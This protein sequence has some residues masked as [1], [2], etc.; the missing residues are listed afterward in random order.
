MKRVLLRAPIFTQSGYGVHARQI[1]RWL[2]KKPNIDLTVQPLPWG[3]T[4]WF[5]K[6]PDAA[7][8]SLRDKFDLAPS[9]YDVSIQLQLPSEWDTSLSKTTIGVT[10]GIETTLAS[11]QWAESC[12][13]LQHIIVPSNHAKSSLVKAGA[14]SNNIKIVPESFSDELFDN[15]KCPVEFEEDFGILIVSQL[16]G[17]TSEVDRKNIFNTIKAI[18]EAFINNN[19]CTI[20]LKT[21]SS[22]NT[23]ID[24]TIVRNVFEKF[25]SENCKSGPKIRIVHGN[26][27][28]AEMGS[29]YRHPKIKC[30]VS[31]TRGEG[32]GLPCLEA[33]ACG[34]PVIA[35]D[36]S[37]HTEYLNL[38][39]W[40]KIP[41]QLINIPQNKVDNFIFVN[42]AQWAEPDINAFKQK[43]LKLYANYAMPKDW[44]L[45]LQKQIRQKYNEIYVESLWDNTL[46]SLL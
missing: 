15:V 32:F 17:F 14:N 36:W 26:L 29:L 41:H 24:A 35:T 38:G 46:E 31:L 9:N 39:K 45:E 21:N 37:A 8:D 12:N 42:N 27:S 28:N 19:N 13:K 44:A 18:R 25:V 22:R 3:A 23:A 2:L 16:T 7:I 33:A 11:T 34:L 10:A 30:F 1:A 40:T 5:L 4:P 43:L 20:I 6:G